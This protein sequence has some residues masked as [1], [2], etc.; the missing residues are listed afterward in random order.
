MSEYIE[1]AHWSD[2]ALEDWPLVY[3]SPQEVA[4]KGSGAVKLDVGFGKLMDGLRR[5]MGGPVIVSSW[6]RSPS[7]NASIS[8][9]GYNGPHTT[10]AAADVICHHARALKV[11]R[12]ALGAGVVRIGVQQR[13]PWSSRFIHLDTAPGFD[14]ALWTY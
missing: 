1:A 14:A 7:H 9:T 5:H 12:Y 8:S 4:C 6:Y 13:G 11:M 2:V 3:F 10:G